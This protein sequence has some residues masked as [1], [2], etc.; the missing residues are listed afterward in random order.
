VVQFEPCPGELGRAARAPTYL[1]GVGIPGQGVI[2]G[3]PFPRKLSM[4]TAT[5]PEEYVAQ[6]LDQ[7]M[8]V[9]PFAQ[10]VGLRE[11]SWT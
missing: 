1:F 5:H 7:S 8:D 3:S 10:A 6:G 4:G 2:D 11:Y 9:A